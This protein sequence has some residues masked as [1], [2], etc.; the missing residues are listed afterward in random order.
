MRSYLIVV[1]LAIVFVF[2]ANAAPVVAAGP[3][4][5]S[6][7]YPTT[8]TQPDGFSVS[9]DGGA[10]VDSAPQ[11][12]AGGVRLHYDVG[13][14]SAGSHAVTV[15]AY[16]NDA[17]YGRMESAASV[18]TFVKPGPPAAPTGLGLSSN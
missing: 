6:D 3:Y 4:V 5:I 10:T 7:A 17:V 9:V 8:V 15:K 16:K 13:A 1:L 18:F 14:V 2:S 12:V 11:S